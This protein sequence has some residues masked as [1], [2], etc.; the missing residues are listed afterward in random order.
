[1]LKSAVQISVGIIIMFSGIITFLIPELIDEIRPTTIIENEEVYLLGLQEEEEWLVIVVDFPDY[2]SSDSI[3]INQAENILN[4]QAVR[5]IDEMSGSKS[6]LNI[7]VHESVIRAN[8]NLADYGSDYMGN[9]DYD[10]SGKFLP[11]KL[12][13]EVITKSKDDIDWEKFDLDND[14]NVDRLLILHTTTGQEDGGGSS[15]RIWSHFSELEEKQSVGNSLFVQHY[16]LASLKSP[17]KGL[18]TMIHEMLHQ[19]G[20]AD[21]YP[22]HDA[23]W[24]DQWKGL[25]QWDIMASGNWNGN[26]AWPA[27]PTSASLELMGIERH[28]E[29]ELT[30]LR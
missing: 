18:G 25:G 11:P 3:G 20:A 16:A 8:G 2:P 28:Q 12:A 17:S 5:Y 6:V 9:V 15:D 10:E 7:T 22:V 26:G 21:L 24:A 19:L 4:E 30:W 14:G 29:I 27:L 1:M 23:N 13:Q